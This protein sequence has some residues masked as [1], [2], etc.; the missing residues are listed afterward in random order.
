[1]D[2]VKILCI[3][4]AVVVFYCLY[5]INSEYFTTPTNAYVAPAFTYENFQQIV[6]T[7]GFAP[8]NVYDF[9][10]EQI[11]ARSSDLER[12]AQIGVLGVI[13]ERDTGGFVDTNF[14]A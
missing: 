9:A 3:A 1:M 10:P 13:G 12:A 14:N 8:G 5:K 6:P 4:S 11:Q 7:S 2:S